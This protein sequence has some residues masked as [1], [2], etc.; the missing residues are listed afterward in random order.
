MH[1]VKAISYWLQNKG[2]SLLS[3]SAAAIQNLAWRNAK[4]FEKEW[5]QLIELRWKEQVQWDVFKRRRWVK[6]SDFENKAEKLTFLV[7]QLRWF[8]FMTYFKLKHH[9]NSA[10]TASYVLNNVLLPI[11]HPIIWHPPKSMYS[12]FDL[13]NTTKE[14]P[15]SFLFTLR[16]T[17]RLKKGL[18]G[19]WMENKMAGGVKADMGETGIW[20]VA[21]SWYQRYFHVR[22]FMWRLVFHPQHCQAKGDCGM[23][24]HYREYNVWLW[25]QTISFPDADWGLRLKKA[26]ADDVGLQAIDTTFTGHFEI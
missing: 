23:H 10:R 26:M 4:T 3:N 16:G 15:L 21:S 13:N 14:H 9:K 5:C 12:I 24:S 7:T 1:L 19:K 18:S 20:I 6:S 25:T 8:W 17:M 22:E 11:Y 2:L